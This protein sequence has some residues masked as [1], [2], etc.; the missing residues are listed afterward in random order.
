M[1]RTKKGKKAPGTDFWSRRPMSGRIANTF[2]KV[3]TH[4]IERRLA[5]KELQ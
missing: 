4:R 3:M 2:N 5:K 1:S